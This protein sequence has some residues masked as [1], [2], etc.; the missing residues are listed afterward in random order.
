MRMVFKVKISYIKSA[1]FGVCDDYDD[2]PSEIWMN[3]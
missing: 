2:N 3:K 1:Y